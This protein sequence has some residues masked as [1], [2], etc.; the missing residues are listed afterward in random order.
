MRNGPVSVPVGGNPFCVQEDHRPQAACVNEEEAE[1]KNGAKTELRPAVST[2]HGQMPE[3]KLEP[4]PG[5]SAQVST[6]RLAKVRGTGNDAIADLMKKAEASRV[7][8]RTKSVRP[9]PPRVFCF[10]LHSLH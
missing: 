3:P 9:T 7:S 4:E 6:T 1:D 8:G 10:A 2:E 5:Q